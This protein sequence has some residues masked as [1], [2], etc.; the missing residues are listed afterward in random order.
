LL[1]ALSSS[2]VWV[3]LAILVVAPAAAAPASLTVSVDR[4][5][6]LIDEEVTVDIEGRAL[7]SLDGAKLVVRVKG[8]AELS[9]VGQA[10]PDLPEAH[11][12]V[13][14]LDARPQ[15]PTTTTTGAVTGTAVGTQTG[16]M[17]TTT[18][19]VVSTT[20]T[21]EPAQVGSA[22]DLA[23]GRLGAKVRIPAGKPARPGAYLL[24]VEVKLSGVIVANG[25]AWIGKAAPRDAPL[26]M[27]FVWPVSLGIH[28]DVDG[29][30]TDRVL[31]E[32]IAPDADGAGHLRGL[33]SLPERFPDWEFALAFEPVLLTQ[34][35]DM[36]DGYVRRDDPGSE[37]EVTAG[38]PTAVNAAQVLTA[39]EGLAA[40]TSVEMLVSP[41]AGAD[42]GVLAAEGW[43]DGLEQIQLGKQVMQQILGLE[44]PPRGAFSPDLRLT[45]DSLAY[46]A[47]ASIDH[48]VV[49][50]ELTELLAEP[51]SEGAVAVRARDAGNDRVTLVLAST[52]LSAH[53]AAPWDAEVFAA[54]LAAEIA[55]GSKDAVVVT[56]SRQYMLPPEEFLEDLGQIL[57]DAAWIRTQT[58]TALLRGHAPDTRPVLLETATA[59]PDGYVEKA[60]LESVRAAHAVVADLAAI[61]DP[62]R[63][64]VEAS[65]R[66]L[67]LAESSWWSR[68]GAS[69]RE[70]S[71][72]LEYAER[73]RA[74]AVDELNKVRLS[75]HGSPVIVGKEGTFDIMIH[76][77]ADYPVTVALG[78]QA[79]GI[80]LP[81]GQSQ[82]VGLSPG[83]NVVPVH[84]TDAGGA[85]NLSV[86]VSA[87]RSVL[88]EAGYSLRFITATT[89]LPWA[90]A[91]VVIVAI[92][93]Y[94][95]VRR[96]LRRHRKPRGA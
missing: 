44:T 18:T 1:T 34:L 26:D 52:G 27:A 7:G 88:D 96:S 40:D 46:Y 43:R 69:P 8:P 15:S 14:V 38:D 3:I 22:A 5:L 6:S 33:V 21:T 95:V 71:M 66:S 84:V 91:A 49:G 89:V 25:R 31:E 70:A 10:T 90:A 65:H 73:A 61:A 29:V 72:G 92:G 93:T 20:T 57:E 9:Q 60:L 50:A 51:L 45:S 77:D 58:L 47:G 74:L 64:P 37:A 32:A 78:L 81:D 24:V 2:V 48:V 94:L 62:T 63:A 11:K 67:Y 54:A 19:Q 39:L 36:A 30:Y 80:L 56:P 87:G 59:R 53:M 42:L 85:H 76:N 86:R 4:C 83:S 82:E 23:A 35:R 68:A 12:I 28:R 16:S 55:A 41:Y 13:V 75:G 79:E 17:T